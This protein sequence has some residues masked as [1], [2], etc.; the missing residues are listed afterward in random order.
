MKIKLFSYFS[1]AARL[2]LSTKYVIT[3]PKVL[4]PEDSKICLVPLHGTFSIPSVN[5]WVEVTLLDPVTENV[6]IE[7]REPLLGK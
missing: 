1:S 5:Q 6:L 3:A 4:S 7:K 2:P